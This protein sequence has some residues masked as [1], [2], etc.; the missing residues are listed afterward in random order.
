MLV[1]GA[2]GVLVHE[3]NIHV[4][5]EVDYV[6]NMCGLLIKIWSKARGPFYYHV[7]SLSMRNWLHALKSVGWN[8]SST[9]KLQRRSHWSWE[10]DMQIHT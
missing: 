6:M 5:G 10:M 3:L 7:S 9:P 2:R 4:Y 1:E 8:Y